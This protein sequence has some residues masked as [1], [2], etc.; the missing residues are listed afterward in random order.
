MTDSINEI[1]PILAK[2]GLV[3]TVVGAVVSFVTGD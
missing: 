2:I 3:A 1:V